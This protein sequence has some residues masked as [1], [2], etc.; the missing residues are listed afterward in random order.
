[1]WFY[2]TIL[3]LFIL[4]IILINYNLPLYYQED[5]ENPVKVKDGEIDK[6]YVKLFDKVFDEK[7]MYEGEV[8]LIDEF[9]KKEKHKKILEVGCGL[10]KHFEL[11]SKKYQLEGL[12]RSKA[13]LDIFKVRN[14]LG[15]VKKGDM[16]EENNYPAETFNVILCLKETLYHNDFKDWDDIL[17]N[18]YYWLKPGG[19]LVIHIFDKEKLDPAPRAHSMYKFDEKNRKHSITHFKNFTHDSWWENKKKYV[20]FHEIF[21]IRNDKNKVSKKRHYVHNLD[22]PKKEKIVEKIISNYFKLVKIIPLENLGV[23]DHELYFFKKNKY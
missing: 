21:A 1:M 2:I 5:F 19:I 14:P 18:L 20:K 4:I 11:L 6:L 16:I 15:K 3:L 8:K 7:M 12:E 10:G 22:I 13:F 9:L 17:S 23:T